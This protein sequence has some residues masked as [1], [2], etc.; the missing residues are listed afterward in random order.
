MIGALGVVYGDIGT[1]PLYAVTETFFGHHPLDHTPENIFGAVSLFFWA[2]MLVI[3][4]KYVM[5]IMRADNNGEGGIFALLGLIRQHERK[6]GRGSRLP[7]RLG[8]GIVVGILVGAAF[9][10]GD[11]M[12]TP[13]ISVLSAVEGLEVILPA[14]DAFVIP[15][16]LAILASLFL[17]QRR[18]TQ[19]VGFLFGPVMVVWFVVIA[20]LGVYRLWDHPQ[21]FGAVNPWHAFRFLAAHGTQSFWVL[22][23]VVLC[24]TGGEALY[25]DMGHFGR[26]TIS[27]AWM[28]MVLPCL[29]LNYFGQG[30]MLLSGAPIPRH[31]V[32]YSLAP[33]WAVIPLIVLATV[34]T[35]IASQALI[36]GAYSMTQQAVALGVFPRVKVIHTN[37]DIP[38][39]IY[40]PFINFLL[41]VGCAWLVLAFRSSGALAA[42]YGIAVTGTMSVT[43]LAFAVIARYLWGWRLRYVLPLT[44]LLFAVDGTFFVSNLLKFVQGGY[45]PI[46][47]G[48]V[49]FLV[50]DTWRWGRTWMGH[51]YQKRFAQMSH[52]IEELIHNKSQ[53]VGDTPNT[54]S[55]VVMASRPIVG[56]A[57]QVPPVM[58]VHYHNWRRLPK[59]IIFFSI[60]Q[61]GTPYVAEKD[62][63]TLVPFEQGKDGTVVSVHVRYGYMEQ[64]N[65][66]EVLLDLKQNKRVKIPNEPSKWLI[67]IGA[68]RFVTPGRYWL[69]RWRIAFFA[70]LN[71]LAKPVTDYFGLEADSGVTIETINV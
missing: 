64:P 33:G 45:V 25:A 17:I 11:G 2:L 52:T 43:T 24:V 15:I 1:S 19:Q 9:L 51:V 47:I 36:S 38:G 65:V 14:A 48:L 27:R 34:A 7:E 53:F 46:V 28:M 22:G 50:M 69:E 62:R 20:A 13:A 32:F 30:A 4:F 70:R 37:P 21:I 40:M 57:D 66:R 3:T 12:I 18:G 39:Q 5:L 6:N 63:L 42:A 29:C 26:K 49:I 55:L 41:F 68:E 71:R 58:S 10:Y 54:V 35:I 31:N 59:H 23:A 8:T 60:V 61:Q 44:V 16:T 56:L 67:L